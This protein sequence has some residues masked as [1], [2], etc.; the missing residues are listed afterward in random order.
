MSQLKSEKPTNSSTPQRRL[1]VGPGTTVLLLV[2]MYL[3]GSQLFLKPKV[4]ERSVEA[5]AGTQTQRKPL[6]TK[7]L[8]WSNELHLTATQKNAMERL[9]EEEKVSLAPVEARI[10]DT[11]KE[12]NEFAEKHSSEAVGLKTI[13]AKAVPMSLLSRQK[14]QLEQGFAEQAQAIMEANQREIAEKL[15]QASTK[16]RA[17][18]EAAS[19]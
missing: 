12:F 15:W 19:P 2:L 17:G 8:S 6:V 7:L 10:G 5:S 13:Q 14:R 18:A 3:C 1:L 9:A 11:M 16:Q 4:I